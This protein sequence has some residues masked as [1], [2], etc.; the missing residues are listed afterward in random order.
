MSGET[1]LPP[2]KW[3]TISGTIATTATARV[4][5]C[6]LAT[7]KT[8]EMIV[9]LKEGTSVKRLTASVTKVGS[10]LRDCIY[11][12]LGSDVK[13]SLNFLVDGPDAVLDLTNNEPGTASYEIETLR[14]KD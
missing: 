14:I 1:S 7:F 13:V 2:L 12:I 11:G 5:I 4:V 6:P 9:T 10:E 3:R 8:A